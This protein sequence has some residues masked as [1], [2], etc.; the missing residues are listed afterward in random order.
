MSRAD[1]VIVDPEAEFT[2]EANT[3]HSAGHNTPFAGRTLHG[4]VKHTLR[5]GEIVFG[6]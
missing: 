2:V 6:N 5:D 3:L 4:R 1:I